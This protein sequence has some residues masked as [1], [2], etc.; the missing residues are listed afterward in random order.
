MGLVRT[1]P[2]CKVCYEHPQ[3]SERVAPLTGC[4]PTTTTR[5]IHIHLLTE[6]QSM[7]S[8]RKH[9]KPPDL[10]E[11]CKRLFILQFSISLPAIL[12]RLCHELN[13]RGKRPQAPALLQR[14][15]QWAAADRRR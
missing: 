11:F 12:M 1:P 13:S 8:C 2:G 5:S 9:P 14:T 3:T 4:G 6:V 10:E 15:S 7:H